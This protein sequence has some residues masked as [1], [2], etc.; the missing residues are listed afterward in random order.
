MNTL[1]FYYNIYKNIDVFVKHRYDYTSPPKTAKEVYKEL[2]I[3][4]YLELNFNNIILLFI[5]PEDRYDALNA[6][7]KKYD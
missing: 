4:S 5:K 3:N 2:E 6:I 7:T 1:N